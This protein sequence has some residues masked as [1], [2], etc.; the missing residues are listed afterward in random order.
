M[1]WEPTPET[2][3]W[4]DY[5]PRAESVL[6]RRVRRFQGRQRRQIH[7]TYFDDIISTPTRPLGSW[8]GRS[9]WSTQRQRRG[10]SSRQTARSRPL[11]IP[12]D[13]AAPIPGR[14][15]AKPRQD[16]VGA[17]LCDRFGRNSGLA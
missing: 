2:R 13:H 3:D 12:I 8:P 11:A 7:A 16:G 10:A 17:D 9:S 1:L 14:S 6:S 4:I 15:Y 5:E